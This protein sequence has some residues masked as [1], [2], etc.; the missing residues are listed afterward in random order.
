MRRLTL[1][2]STG[3][4][5][6]RACKVSSKACSCS[7]S[8]AC[9]V[10]TTLLCVLMDTNARTPSTPTKCEPGTLAKQRPEA[11][12]RRD[13]CQ[14]RSLSANNTITKARE[15]QETT[16]TDT[17]SKCDSGRERGLAVVLDGYHEALLE[18][19]SVQESPRCVHLTR[20]QPHR[21]E[22]RLAGLEQA[23]YHLD[24]QLARVDRVTTIRGNQN[25]LVTFFFVMVQGPLQRQ[26][27]ILGLLR[28]AIHSQGEDVR[29]YQIPR[30]LSSE[31]LPVYPL[32]GDQAATSRNQREKLRPTSGDDVDS[33]LCQLSGLQPQRVFLLLTRLECN[34]A[35]LV[36]C[37][38]CLLGSRDSPASSSKTESHSVTRLELECSA[39]IS[40]NRS[41]HLRG[42]CHHTQLI[43]GFLVEKCF[44]HVGHYGLDPLTSGNPPASASQSAGI[45]GRSSQV[46]TC[47]APPLVAWTSKFQR[48]CLTGLELQGSKDPSASAFQTAV[49]TDSLTLSPRLEC[50]GMIS[51]HCKLC[52]PGSSNSSASTSQVAGTTGVC[53]HTQLVFVFSVEMEFH[54]IG[55]AAVLTDEHVSVVGLAE[56]Q[57]TLLRVAVR[58][59]S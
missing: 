18:C 23:D 22:S 8:K 24:V 13:L 26:F 50:S 55:Q 3:E 28:D 17:T 54:H 30:D 40:A 36:Y 43:C 1:A 42:D 38:L 32:C 33:A 45:T 7:W 46:S 11:C 27:R 15:T 37:N 6:S 14:R 4:P 5:W 29:F 58:E 34:G 21:E 56:D 39:M 49:I 12:S 41:L 51:A 48:A 53:H 31:L 44:H 20:V 57:V 35:I 2:L 9:C 47:P 19:V 25:K 10:N 52:L 16:A 59:T